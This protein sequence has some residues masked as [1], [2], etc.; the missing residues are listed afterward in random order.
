MY[1]SPNGFTIIEVLVVVSLIALL[2]TVILPD[3]KS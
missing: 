1:G 2:S 3:F